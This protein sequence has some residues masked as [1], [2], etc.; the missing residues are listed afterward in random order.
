V[1]ALNEAGA[2][3]LTGL[4]F[5]TRLP[6]PKKLKWSEE[7][8]NHATLWLPFYGLITGLLAA[9]V[10][11]LC[12]LG[13]P[14]SPSIALSMIS[15]LLFTGAFHED[16]LADSCDGLGG[17]W[18][19][20][21]KLKIMKDSRIGSYGAIGL[22]MILLLKFSLLSSME[23]RRVA[24]AMIAAHML[25]RLLPVL[26]I[27]RLPY[28]RTDSSS[29]NK[30]VSKGISTARALASILLSALLLWGIDAA[31][32]QSEGF[33]LKPEYLLIP[34]TLLLLPPAAVFMK[35]HLKGYTGD[36]LGASQQ[37]SEVLLYIGLILLWR[38][39]R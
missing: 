26:L 34:L 4:C 15:T 2:S 36:L 18:T 17:G 33:S 7:R 3:F 20:E 12:L 29:K 8:L 30:P 39:W 22:V 1:K 37:V 38:F 11:R 28:A 21:D 32:P 31:F 35:K 27:A 16:G 13:L 6:L 10:Y 9:G 5:Y 25:S 23:P 19:L 14:Q 24:Q